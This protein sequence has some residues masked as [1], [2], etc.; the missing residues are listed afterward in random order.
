MRE[1]ILITHFVSGDQVAAELAGLIGKETSKA[2]LRR[3]AVSLKFLQRVR[4]LLGFQADKSCG[5][6]AEAQMYHFS[7]PF[8]PLPP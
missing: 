4:Q 7:T 6:R 5:S 1:R 2:K 3:L 8:A